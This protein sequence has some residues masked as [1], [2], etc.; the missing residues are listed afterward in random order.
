[1]FTWGE[2]EK[3]VPAPREGETGD[4]ESTVGLSTATGVD[5]RTG[6]RMET[7]TEREA[8]ETTSLL[9]PLQPL[10]TTSSSTSRSYLARIKAHLKSYRNGGEEG[11]VV[12]PSRDNSRF[13]T[14]E[15]AICIEEFVRG[16]LVMQLVASFFTPS[17]FLLFAFCILLLLRESASASGRERWLMFLFIAG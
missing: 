9:H 7:E 8:T 11:N 4:E 2:M 17:C 1:M 13:E 14:T 6:R 10:S 15:C 5:T 16:D 12:A 3:L